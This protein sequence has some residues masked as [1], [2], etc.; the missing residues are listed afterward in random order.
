M[1]TECLVRGDRQTAIQVKDRFLHVMARLVGEMAPPLA[2]LPPVGE[3]PFRVVDVLE[4]GE[5]QFHT[6]E[7]ALEREVVVPE[8]VLGE[9]TVRPQKTP[10]AFPGR[11]E[12]EP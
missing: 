9:L 7:E 10:F 3:P 5:K 8:A 4:V 12:L 11:R 2:E 1:Q 6:W